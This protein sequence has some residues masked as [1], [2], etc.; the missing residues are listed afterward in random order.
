MDAVADLPVELGDFGI[1]SYGGPLFGA[2]DELPHF[3]EE[4]IVG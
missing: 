2:V 3:L 1:D 4:K